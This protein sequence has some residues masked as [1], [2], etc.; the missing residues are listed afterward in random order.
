[1]NLKTI[2]KSV[3]LPPPA[4]FSECYIKSDT[5]ENPDYSS[6][7]GG[8]QGPISGGPFRTLADCGLGFLVLLL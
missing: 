8:G 6:S 3:F 1:M 2:K 7:F 4:Y 5:L